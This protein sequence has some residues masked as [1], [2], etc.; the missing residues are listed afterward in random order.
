VFGRLFQCLE[1]GI[2]RVVR[3]HVH[4]VDHVDLEAGIAGRVHRLLEQLRHFIDAA[5]RCSIHLD[6]VD[7]ATGVDG[8][9]GFAH[10]ARGGGDTAIAVGA[11]A[12]ERLGQDA[13]ERGFAHPARPGEQVGMVQAARGRA[14]FAGEDLIGHGAILPQMGA[15]AD[16]QRP[17]PVA[18]AARAM[19]R[20]QPGAA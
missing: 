3:Q 11:D 9:A 16:F 17:G 10:A 1:H 12:I 19:R 15:V 4:L 13:R 14:V 6:V 18:V 7:K 5:V 8:G 20:P 2:E